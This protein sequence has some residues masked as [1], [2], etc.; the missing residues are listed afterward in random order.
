MAGQQGGR[1]RSARKGDTVFP[2]FI[3]VPSVLDACVTQHQFTAPC[4]LPQ[5][6]PQPAC[7]KHTHSTCTQAPVRED[8]YLCNNSLAKELSLVAGETGLQPAHLLTPGYLAIHGFIFSFRQTPLFLPAIQFMRNLA[9]RWF[10][11]FFFHTAAAAFA[12]GREDAITPCLVCADC[13]PGGFY[14]Q[15]KACS[16]TWALQ[17]RRRAAQGS[18]CADKSSSFLQGTQVCVPDS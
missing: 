4:H 14:L 6:D 9:R 10:F 15:Y 5:R 11:L 17:V 12:W 7:C 13:W 1:R 18:L 3:R 2:Y 16:H 8:V